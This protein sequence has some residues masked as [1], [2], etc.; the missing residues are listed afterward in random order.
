M[1]LLF[2]SK[3]LFFFSENYLTISRRVLLTFN[4]GW[5]FAGLTDLLEDK[6][7]HLLDFEVNVFVHLMHIVLQTFEFRVG[8][9]L[10]KVLSILYTS[11]VFF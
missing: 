1:R 9:F 10:D 6:L 7:G 4:D 2:S 3:F 8:V 5:L 11:R